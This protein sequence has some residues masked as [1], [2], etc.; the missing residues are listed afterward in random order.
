V[1]WFSYL[2]CNS[3]LP[4]PLPLL[5]PP[6]PADRVRNV[7]V[8]FPS[9]LDIFVELSSRQ[10][11]WPWFHTSMFACLFVCFFLSLIFFTVLVYNV[12][13]WPDRLNACCK[14]HLIGNGPATE[15][16][17]TEKVKNTKRKNWFFQQH[18]VK[19]PLLWEKHFKLST[20]NQLLEILQA[21]RGVSKQ[22]LL[23]FENEVAWSPSV[24]PRHSPWARRRF[25]C[26][27]I[28]SQ[29]P[30]PQFTVFIKPDVFV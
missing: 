10:S 18:Y 22:F 2:C 4:P 12:T 6:Q 24:G 15:L 8:S 26:T 27:R 29:T 25:K 13:R 20:P 11:R 7:A 3:H 30:R 14:I 17:N 9:F 28:P 21:W 5:P 1:C 16:I 23:R 19:V